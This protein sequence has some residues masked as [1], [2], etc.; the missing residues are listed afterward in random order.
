VIDL[1]AIDLAAIELTGIELTGIELTGIERGKPTTGVE[2][3]AD[4]P[5]LVPACSAAA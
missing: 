3:P 5:L 4:G 2:R 1:A